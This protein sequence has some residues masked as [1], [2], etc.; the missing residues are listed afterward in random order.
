MRIAS[1]LTLAAILLSTAALGC[2][3]QATVPMDDAD[4][5]TTVGPAT[6]TS[7]VIDGWHFF[8]EPVS[9]DL[10][11]A[12][13]ADVLAQPAAYSGREVQLRGTIAEVCEKKGCWLRIA[14]PSGGEETVFVKFTCPIEADARLIPADAAGREVIVAGE[15]VVEEMDEATARHYAE[16]AGK[17]AE[18]VAQ[19]VGPQKTIRVMSP[20]AR[21]KA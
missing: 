11:S 10:P 4:A 1:L 15:V 3:R 2:R 9:T 17:S 5:G 18:E 7:A 14:D 6:R 19:I 20:S 12:D 13:V 16:D 21:V 8:G